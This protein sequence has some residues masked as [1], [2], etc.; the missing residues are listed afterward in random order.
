M[1][2]C[3]QDHKKEWT[4]A[5]TVKRFKL[6]HYLSPTVYAYFL[7]CEVWFII[8]I[9]IIITTTIITSLFIVDK[10]IKYW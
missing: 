5:N 3:N 1:K 6:M 8:I 4:N 2:V 7:W 10:I 9:I